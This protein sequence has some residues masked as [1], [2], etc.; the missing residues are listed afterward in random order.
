MHLCGLR[1]YSPRPTRSN[2]T[3]A[4]QI[5]S[6]GLPGPGQRTRGW[7]KNTYCQCTTASHSDVM[8]LRALQT[9]ASAI[10]GNSCSS[11][12]TRTT[13]N[14]TSSEGPYLPISRSPSRLARSSGTGD[15]AGLA[16]SPAGLIK[17]LGTCRCRAPGPCPSQ[18]TST[19]LSRLQPPCGLQIS[20]ISCACK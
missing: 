1:C 17:A 18:P 19:A 11:C 6:A 5:S 8:A 9:E 20:F 15:T 12:A 2:G 3:I 16:S 7:W 10:L 13:S 14:L 4:S